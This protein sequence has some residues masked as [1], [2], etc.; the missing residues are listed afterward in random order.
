MR[1]PPAG[2]VLAVG[3]GGAVGTLA[4]HGVTLALDSVDV[5]PWGTLVVNLAGS[6]LLGLVVAVVASSTLRT[7]LGTG[8]LGGF[9]TY[10]AF[11]LQT[12]DLLV[13]RPSL[14]VGYALATL[15]GG[16]LLALVGLAAGR[17]WAR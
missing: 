15:A 11:A 10:S 9:T 2:L 17:R 8:V 12:H 7:T 4:R 16:W 3:L 14:A 13:D 6:L 1:T 5:L